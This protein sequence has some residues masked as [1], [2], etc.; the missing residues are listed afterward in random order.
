MI[1]LK[2]NSKVNSISIK[3]EGKLK[4][5]NPLSFIEITNEQVLEV[6]KKIKIFPSLEI[7]YIKD[8][9]KKETKQIKTKASNDINI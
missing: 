4:K 8:V 6:N 7:I 3:I 9:K 2:N 5:I 1:K